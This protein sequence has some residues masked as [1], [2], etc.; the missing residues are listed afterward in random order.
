LL[1]IGVVHDLVN[2]GRTE[3]IVHPFLGSGTTAVAAIMEGRQFLG[4]DIDPGC[5]E[6]TRRRL[7]SW[8]PVQAR[9]LATP[10]R[11][12]RRARRFVAGKSPQLMR[13]FAA[14]DGEPSED[15]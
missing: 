11:D 12:H 5:V 3:L 9:K 15:P 7:S 14:D 13:R 2:G 1:D 8:R 10:Q 6:T 4:C